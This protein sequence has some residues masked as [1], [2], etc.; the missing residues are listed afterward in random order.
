MKLVILLKLISYIILYMKI[1]FNNI[2]FYYLTCNNPIRKK[3]IIEEFKD[4][5][6]KEVNPVMGIGKVKS[7]VTGISRILDLACQDQ[8]RDKPFKPFIAL[9]DDVIKYRKFPDFIEIPDDTDIFYIG[10]SICGMAK[11]RY[12]LNFASKNINPDIMKIYNMQ[13]L[14]GIIVCSPR[15][16]LA[17]QKCC[18]ESFLKD[19]VIDIFTAQIQPYL[20]VYALKTPLV[21]QFGGEINGVKIG[22]A[23]GATKRDF[24]NKKSCDMPDEWI[25][26]TNISII[27]NYKEKEPELEEDLK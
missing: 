18:M 7:Q 14:H 10:V 4:Y 24:Y 27:T 22:G 5:N 23:E 3:M 11:S 6:L 9:E 1:S 13:S 2:T 15:G 16:L 25:N 19:K 17:L 12:Y 20:N 8:E 21:Y 26:K